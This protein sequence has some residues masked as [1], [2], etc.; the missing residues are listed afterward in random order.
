[1]ASSRVLVHGKRFAVSLQEETGMSSQSSIPEPEVTIVAVS[2][3]LDA[4][5]SWRIVARNG[6]RLLESSDTFSRV[7]DA[8]E[9]GRRHVRAAVGAGSPDAPRPTVGTG[10]NDQA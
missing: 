7:G 5:W 8:L 9:D 1:V 6:D 4:R 3:G 10:L 2:V